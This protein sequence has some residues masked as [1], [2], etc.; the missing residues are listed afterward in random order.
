[1]QTAVGEHARSPPCE[2]RVFGGTKRHVGT[3]SRHAS[4]I[5]SN[6]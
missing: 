4:V 6:P 3:V 2:V 5:V 1:V